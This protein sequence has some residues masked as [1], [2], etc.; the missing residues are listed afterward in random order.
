MDQ[1]LS[2]LVAYEEWTRTE[3]EPKEPPEGPWEDEWID[4]GGEG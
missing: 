2:P 4:L 3:G 1:T